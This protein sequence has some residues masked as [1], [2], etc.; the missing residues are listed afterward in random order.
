MPVL[1]RLFA[2]HASNRCNGPPGL[3][4][5]AQPVQ[6]ISSKSTLP[7]TVVR[8]CF[9]NPLH[10]LLQQLEVFPCTTIGAQQVQLDESNQRLDGWPL[11]QLLGNKV[12]RCVIALSPAIAPTA[13]HQGV[14]S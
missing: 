14:D 13:N 8:L 7:T 2:L 12:R 5:G 11:A 3:A 9:Q 1:M 4:A 6:L 10:Q